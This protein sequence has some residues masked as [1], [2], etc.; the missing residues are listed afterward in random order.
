MAGPCLASVAG[1]ADQVVLID[2]GSEGAVASRIGREAG[3][4]VVRCPVNTG[5]A[6]AVNLGAGIARGT[7]WPC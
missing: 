1:Q 7:S 2:N 5:F 3:A 4:T 6:P